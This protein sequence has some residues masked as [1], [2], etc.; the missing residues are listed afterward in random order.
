MDSLIE[1]KYCR[2]LIYGFLLPLSTETCKHGIH[3][4][5][6]SRSIAVSDGKKVQV[7][8]IVC[9]FCRK[10]YPIS[11]KTKRRLLKYYPEGDSRTLRDDLFWWSCAMVPC[12]MGNVILISQE[13]GT[14]CLVVAQGLLL[15]KYWLERLW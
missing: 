15:Y 10:R 8:E 2:W 13:A 14:F 1:N 7:A 6:L 3:S 11:E 12:A 5:T 9:C 4:K